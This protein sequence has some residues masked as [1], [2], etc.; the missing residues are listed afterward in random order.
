MEQTN[1]IVPHYNEAS[2]WMERHKLPVVPALPRYVTI[3]AKFKLKLTDELL[4]KVRY[5][6]NTYPTKEW[7]GALFYRIIEGD[8]DNIEN[9]VIEAFDLYVMDLG[10]G[11]FTESN[12]TPEFGVYIARHP[13]LLDA[14][15]GWI[16]SHNNMGAFFS[17]TDLT[18][19]DPDGGS[20]IKFATL[21]KRWLSLVV[22]NAGHAVSKLAVASVASET[23]S[24]EVEGFDFTVKNYSSAKDKEPLVIV[25][26]AEVIKNGVTLDQDFLES[27]ELIRSK[28]LKEEV[29]MTPQQERMAYTDYNKEYK[30][31][32]Y[33]AKVGIPMVALFVCKLAAQ[34]YFYHIINTTDNFA[35]NVA[36]AVSCVPK[37]DYKLYGQMV[38]DMIEPLMEY[39]DIND[40]DA[41][42]NL[43]ETA[44]SQ[45]LPLRTKSKTYEVLYN[46]LEEYYQYYTDPVETEDAVSKEEMDRIYGEYQVPDY[47]V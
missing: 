46:Q 43:I 31:S 4:D 37:I 29:P 2:S 22:N 35:N 15:E 39:M 27:V 16:H 41:Q 14:Q 6:C 42:T 11:A 5:L 23:S 7:S 19:N 20:L 44:L 21:S 38:F 47:R 1:L 28:Q 3:D 33:S 17:S 8:I 13:E 26:N 10:S 32:Q 24:I 9:L 34:A 25:Y 12:H 40:T 18:N 45:L 36:R 30:P